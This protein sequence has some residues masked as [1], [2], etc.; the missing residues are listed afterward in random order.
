MIKLF[1]VIIVLGLLSGCSSG[2]SPYDPSYH[3]CMDN[4]GKNSY[5]VIQERLVNAC[6]L[7]NGTYAPI[8]NISAV[9]SDQID[10]TKTIIALVAHTN[11]V[12]VTQLRQ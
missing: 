5:P 8:T 3:N 4:T 7:Y 12:C 1:L 10:G 2:Q 11:Q 9:C 6:R